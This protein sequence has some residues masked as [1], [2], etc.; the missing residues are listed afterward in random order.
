MGS[1]VVIGRTSTR[2]TKRKR[3]SKKVDF[4]FFNSKV[5]KIPDPDKGLEEV[6]AY[7]ESLPNVD[8]PEI[9][10]MHTNASISYQQN[11]S[12]NLL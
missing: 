3:T 7:I 2:T 6:H 4:S 5:Y 8:A 12:K 10:G 1:V 11:E 9:F